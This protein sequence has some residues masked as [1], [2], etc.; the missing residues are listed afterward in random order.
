MV[1]RVVRTQ[2]GDS[3]FDR[4][5]DSS[6]MIKVFQGGKYEGGSGSSAGWEEGDWN[7]DGRF[8][9]S[10]MIFAFQQGG[11]ESEAAGA[12]MAP[13]AAAIDA[14]RRSQLHRRR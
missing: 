12:T 13:T 9:S 5:F 7:G 11:Y 8:D 3:N 1:R 4:R 14:L 2:C 6:D 10:D